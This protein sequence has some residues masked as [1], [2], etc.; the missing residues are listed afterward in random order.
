MRLA[1]P[2]PDP[3]HGAGSAADDADGWSLASEFHI[4]RI[5]IETAAPL[6][7]DADLVV[8][9]TAGDSTKAWVAAC[10][11]A[12]PEVADKL[13]WWIHEIDVDLYGNDMAP[14]EKAALALFD[15][16]AARAA[17]AE[18]VRLPRNARVLHPA[19]SDGFVEKTEQPRLPFPTDRRRSRAG[20]PFA[21]H[22]ER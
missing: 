22:G 5:P 19:L 8:A 9:N 17:W 21:A 3:L 4:P 1:C 10:L 18:T 11:D 15:T 14:L 20:R 16:E 13:V 12:A 2:L 7:R 6:A